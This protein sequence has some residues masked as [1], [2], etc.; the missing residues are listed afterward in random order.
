V[1]QVLRQVSQVPAWQVRL[2]AVH[3]GLGPVE[4]EQQHSLDQ[5]KAES[6]KEMT[7]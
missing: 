2:W 6:E 3:P 4:Q 7:T 1:Q 5:A